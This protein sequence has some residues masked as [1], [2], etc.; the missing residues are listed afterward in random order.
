M[1]IPVRQRGPTTLQRCVLLTVL[2]AVA[3]IGWL[4]LLTSAALLPQAKT[5]ALAGVATGLVV[6]SAALWIQRM[7]GDE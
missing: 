5:A 2:A 7:R 6:G 3:A 4:Y 1:F